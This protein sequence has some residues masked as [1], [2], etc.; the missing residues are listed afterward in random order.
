[1]T[2]GLV[3]FRWLWL[4]GQ[5]ERSKAVELPSTFYPWWFCSVGFVTA[6]VNRFLH[7]FTEV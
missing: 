7:S 5:Q 1:M 3:A 6:M 2:L 4:L